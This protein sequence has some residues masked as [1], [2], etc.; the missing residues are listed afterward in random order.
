[1]DRESALAAAC[2][3][4]DLEASALSQSP[5]AGN[6]DISNVAWHDLSH[7][8]TDSAIRVKNPRYAGRQ[9]RIEAL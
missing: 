2:L 3:N 8:A 7:F 4:G 9:V 6:D 1:M 5:D